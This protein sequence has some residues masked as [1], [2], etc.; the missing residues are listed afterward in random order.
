VL[1][2]GQTGDAPT[3]PALIEAVPSEC[4]IKYAAADKAYDSDA[5]RQDLADRKIKAVIPS[6]ACRNPQIPHDRRRYR[7][8]N[9]VERLVGRLKQFRRIATRYEKLSS[10]FLALIHLTAAFIMIR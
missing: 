9:N 10:T 1:T 8:R 3:Y 5:I 7:E 4:P 2:P 6:L